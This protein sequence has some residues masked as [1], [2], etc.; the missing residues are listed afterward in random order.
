MNKEVK[1]KKPAC[2]TLKKKINETVQRIVNREILTG[3]SYLFNHLEETS[4]TYLLDDIYNLHMNT[5]EILY[6]YE[7]DFKLW[8]KNNPDYSTQ[9]AIETFCDDIMDSGSDFKE[10]YQW[11]IVSEWLYNKLNEQL[12]PVCEFE[13]VYFWGRCGMNYSLEDEHCIVEIAKKIN[14]Y[15]T[16][17]SK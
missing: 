9:K 8:K 3:A 12:E 4:E 14:N 13:D 16:E 11:F 2:N 17:G 7:Y 10:V 1:R 6:N 5:D 15:K